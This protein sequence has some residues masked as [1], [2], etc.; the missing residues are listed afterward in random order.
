[1]LMPACGRDLQVA[2]PR[3]EY[4]NVVFRVEVDHVK[5]FRARFRHREGCV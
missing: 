3:Y 5:D 1:M 2:V 4:N